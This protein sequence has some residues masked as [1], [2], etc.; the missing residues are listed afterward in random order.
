MT[1]GAGSLTEVLDNIVGIPV[2]FYVLHNHSL[3]TY[4]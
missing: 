2:K 4:R 1:D 3:H